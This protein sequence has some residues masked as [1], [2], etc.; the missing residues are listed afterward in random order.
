MIP[1]DTMNRRT[2]E[3]CDYVRTIPT[4]RT[5][6]PPT[7][8]QERFLNAE[9]GGQLQWVSEKGLCLA[10]PWARHEATERMEEPPSKFGRFR[11]QKDS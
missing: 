10:L 5:G 11:S 3:M 9:T 8:R 4:T 1:D 2:E 6:I 7:G